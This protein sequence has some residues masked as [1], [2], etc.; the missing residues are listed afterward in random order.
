[1]GNKPIKPLH[2]VI[3]KPTP[4]IIPCKRIYHKERGMVDEKT[5]FTI[6]FRTDEEKS[7]F[8]DEFLIPKKK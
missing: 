5:T 2:K 7:L 1:M 3:D 6:S 4:I 8:L